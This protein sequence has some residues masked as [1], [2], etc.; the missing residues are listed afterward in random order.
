MNTKAKWVLRLDCSCPKCG[1][2]IDL[3]V[4]DVV[5]GRNIEACEHGTPRTRNINVFCPNCT[6]EFLTDLEY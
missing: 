3:T 6:K 2:I 4:G 5:W 1:G